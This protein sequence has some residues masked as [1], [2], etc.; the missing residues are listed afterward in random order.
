[1]MI[2]EKA[3]DAI[4]GVEPLPPVG[5]LTELFT[6]RGTPTVLKT[7]PISLIPGP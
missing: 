1:M 2:A 5:G 7:G 6:T 3:A 4:L